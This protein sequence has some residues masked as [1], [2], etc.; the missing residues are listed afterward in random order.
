MKNTLG[1]KMQTKKYAK[2]GAGDRR[3]PV[4]DE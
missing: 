1:K 3:Q 4:D 2:K